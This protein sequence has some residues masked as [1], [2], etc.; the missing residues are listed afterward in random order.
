M[1]KFIIYKTCFE[2][3]QT[4]FSTSS[5]DCQLDVVGAKEIE[6]E[7]RR[8]EILFRTESFKFEVFLQL[9]LKTFGGKILPTFQM[10]SSWR[11]DNQRNDTRHYGTQYNHSI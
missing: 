9:K 7:V 5:Q 1:L 4:S 8:L 10:H 2:Q 11:H 6:V 3:V